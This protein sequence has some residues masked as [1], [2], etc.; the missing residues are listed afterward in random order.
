MREVTQDVNVCHA[1]LGVL[2]IVL[3][4]VAM[5]A[6][7]CA[8]ATL[9]ERLASGNVTQVKVYDCRSKIGPEIL[10]STLATRDKVDVVLRL[11]SRYEDGWTPV[12]WSVAS[13]E[14]RLDC[15]GTTLNGEKQVRQFR[16]ARNSVTTY[17]NGKAYWQKI[18]PADQASLCRLVGLGESFFTDLQGSPIH[19][20]GR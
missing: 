5:Y 8:A 12:K 9:P 16:V 14:L 11:L 15:I 1:R 20:R 13:G 3:I 19:G 6:A 10:A 18:S 7:G 17:I 2:G 4:P